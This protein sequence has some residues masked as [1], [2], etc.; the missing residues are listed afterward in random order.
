MSEQISKEIDIMINHE[1][2][3]I[4]KAR[5]LDEGLKL[6]SLDTCRRRETALISGYIW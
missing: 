1:V 6:D 4:E 3:K 2:K 5:Q